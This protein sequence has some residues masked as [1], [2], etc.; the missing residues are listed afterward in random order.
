MTTFSYYVVSEYEH[1][2][3]VLVVGAVDLIDAGR[4]AQDMT[5][6]D[7][8]ASRYSVGIAYPTAE[9][10]VNAAQHQLRKLGVTKPIYVQVSH[11]AEL[12]L[13]RAR[14]ILEAHAT[15]AIC[16]ICGL[17]A[18]PTHL[19]RKGRTY[20]TLACVSMAVG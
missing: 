18:W 5:N 8:M 16:C 10:A 12:R 7:P 13:D 19:E 9:D 17:W 3:P 1:L 14:E 2:T 20:C 15:R 6:S 11:L 4:Y